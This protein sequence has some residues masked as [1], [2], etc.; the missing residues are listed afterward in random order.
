MSVEVNAT[1][2][3]KTVFVEVYIYYIYVEQ[4]DFL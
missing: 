1:E 4:N 3:E 2:M